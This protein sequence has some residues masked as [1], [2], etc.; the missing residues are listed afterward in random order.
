MGLAPVRRQRVPRADDGDSRGGWRAAAKADSNLARRSPSPSS[1]PG[2]PPPKP[3]TQLA[4]DPVAALSQRLADVLS[5]DISGDSTTFNLDA[6]PKPDARGFEP[7]V[8]EA[9]LVS[10]RR[11]RQ[12]AAAAGFKLPAGLAASE[13]A[14]QAAVAP[15]NAGL[16][17][18]FLAIEVAAGA[19]SYGVQL[20]NVELLMQAL[21]ADGPAAAWPGFD[22]A[23]A[24]AELTSLHRLQGELGVLL[25]VGET[26][27]PAGLPA[28]LAAG[29][30]SIAE[31]EAQLLQHYTSQ[32]HIPAALAPAPALVPRTIPPRDPGTPRR[33]QAPDAAAEWQQV[34]VSRGTPRGPRLKVKRP[35]AP[36]AALPAALAVL[37]PAVAAPLA[38]ADSASVLAVLQGLPDLPPQE[39]PDLQPEVPALAPGPARPS[40]RPSALT[41]LANLQGVKVGSMRPRGHRR[42]VCARS[43]QLK[44]LVPGSCTLLWCWALSLGPMGERRSQMTRRMTR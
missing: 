18:T 2:E 36:V 8:A 30:R 33:Q 34:A 32:A 31:L 1:S 43:Y 4:Y 39:K 19:P 11:L 13:A 27:A 44:L 16:P 15:S 7:G 5:T 42:T 9:E 28:L 3:V 41:P 40:A 29:R 23:A 37:A 35:A 20:S 22:T 24:E 14:L 25:A 6:S 10:L 26:A 17:A 12:D 21:P 38:R